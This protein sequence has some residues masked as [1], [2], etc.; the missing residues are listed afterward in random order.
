MG[1]FDNIRTL[2]TRDRQ[3]RQSQL[4]LCQQLMDEVGSCISFKQLLRCHQHIFSEGICPPGLDCRPN[5]MF[6]EAAAQLTLDKVYLGNICGLFIKNARYW[7]SSK[8]YMAR[9]ICLRQWQ[10][11][12]IAGLTLYAES[13]SQKP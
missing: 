12:L 5:G 4:R 10:N 8:D 1:I 9:D 6:R 13:I 7:E 11:A 2:I 3:F